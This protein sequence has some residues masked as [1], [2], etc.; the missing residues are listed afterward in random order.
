MD[1]TGHPRGQLPQGVMGKVELHEVLQ[2]LERVLVE[3]HVVQ[4][5]LVEVKKHQVLQLVEDP[6]GDLGDVV[7]A[8]AQLLQ[9]GGQEVRHLPELVLLHVKEDQIIQ[10]LQ[11]PLVHLLDA[12]VVQ[13]DPLQLCGILEGLFR[14]V[15]DEVVLKVEIVDPGGDDGH[16]P[17]VA[18][19][20][21][22]GGGEIWGAETFSGAV[23]E[24]RG[25]ARWQGWRQL[26]GLNWLGWPASRFPWRLLPLPVHLKDQQEDER[27]KQSEGHLHG[28]GIH[29]RGNRKNSFKTGPYRS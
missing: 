12:V 19:I 15:L 10:F 28:P 14:E 24:D 1:G 6:G 22:K 16:L 27:E 23:W 4:F 25:G 5:V 8:Q 13:V 21:V 17:Q 7:P 3:V 29:L 9:V 26:C 2:A 18:A 20:T 11:D